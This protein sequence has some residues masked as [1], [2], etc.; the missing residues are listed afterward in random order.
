[1]TALAV[2]HFPKGFA[3]IKE[4]KGKEYR[5]RSKYKNTQ[6]TKNEFVDLPC[7]ASPGFP[8]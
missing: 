8:V 6:A 7:P 2:S 3:N 1:M 5:E 4:Q